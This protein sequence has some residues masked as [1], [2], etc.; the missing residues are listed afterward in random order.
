[1]NYLL[2]TCVLSETVRPR[3][4]DAVLR[5]LD[6]QDEPRLFMSALTL[7]EIH[8]GIEKLGD[9]IRKT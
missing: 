3:P 9:A 4:E 6:S 1:M 7:G 8:Q 2:D 5:W